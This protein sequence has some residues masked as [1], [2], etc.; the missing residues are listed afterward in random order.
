MEQAVNKR[1]RAN[2]EY[3]VDLPAEL[4]EGEANEMLGDLVA[5]AFEYLDPKMPTGQ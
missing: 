1:W 3:E 2:I 5:Q 4:D